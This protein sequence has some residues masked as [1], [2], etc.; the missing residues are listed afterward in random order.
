MSE[1]SENI[2]KIVENVENELKGI[3]V[4]VINF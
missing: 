3:I 1:L 2:K 4:S